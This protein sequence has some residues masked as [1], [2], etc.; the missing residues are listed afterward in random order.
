MQVSQKTRLKLGRVGLL[1]ITWILV[2]FYSTVQEAL[3]LSNFPGLIDSEMLHG[4]TPYD[5]FLSVIILVIG[6]GLIVGLVEVFW[7]QRRAR[8]LRFGR[9]LATRSLFYIAIVLLMSILASFFYNTSISDQPPWSPVVLAEVQRSVLSG[10]LL[11]SLLPISLLVVLTLTVIQVSN[12]FGPGMLPRFIAGRYFDPTEELRAFMFIDVKSSTTIAEDIG[13][14]KFFGFINQ[15]IQ[16]AT[17]PILAHS[18]EIY[19]YVGDEIIISWTASSARS[20]IPCFHA[21]QDAINAASQRYLD[22]YG[23]VP[24]L[25]AGA[26]CGPVIV[27]EIGILK[28]EIMYLGDVLNTTARI[29]A[30][31]NQYGHSLLVTTDILALQD[32]PDY[33]IQELGDL[34][35]RGKVTPTHI[36]GIQ[37]KTTPA[38]Q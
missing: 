25:K 9:V 11:Y 33:T 21:V 15:F 6:S 20:C 31:C 16:D 13:N 23:Y 30:L 14:I 27:G 8:R 29:Q 18:G 37:R 1:I 19:K 10:S 3:F 2:A 22:I 36:L 24:E 28:K 12:I 4:Y 26:H 7:F 38:Q 17:D 32:S 34:P 5:S 35:L